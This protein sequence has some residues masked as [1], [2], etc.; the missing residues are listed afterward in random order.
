MC[1]DRKGCAASHQKILFWCS[2]V[3][4]GPPVQLGAG[5]GLS[6]ELSPTLPKVEFRVLARFRSYRS[7]PRKSAE[8]SRD[9]AQ[10][11]E[12]RRGQEGIES[13]SVRRRRRGRAEQFRRRSCGASIPTPISAANSLTTCHTAFSVTPSPQGPPSRQHR[14]VNQKGCSRQLSFA[15]EWRRPGYDIDRGRRPSSSFQCAILSQ[16]D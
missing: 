3:F 14:L 5:P 6:P 10:W 16:V 13:V 11:S 8:R 1:R 7:P 12:S 2:R 9:N 4:C 15:L